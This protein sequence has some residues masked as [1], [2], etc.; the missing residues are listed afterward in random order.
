MIDD[1]YHN[2]R[3]LFS[4]LTNKKTALDF[5]YFNDSEG[6]HIEINDTSFAKVVLFIV[7][8]SFISV[9][10]YSIDLSF[11]ILGLCSH[12]FLYSN[13]RYIKTL[14]SIV[15]ADDEQYNIGNIIYKISIKFLFI[16][17]Y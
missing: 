12:F 10:I 13:N 17:F 5:F 9:Y 6:Q 8:S 11:I 14:K 4:C 15:M 7:S 16:L 3:F 2:T 1:H